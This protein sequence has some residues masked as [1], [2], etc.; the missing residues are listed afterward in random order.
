MN[1]NLKR[2]SRKLARTLFRKIMLWCT[3]YWWW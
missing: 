1:V 2:F 3:T